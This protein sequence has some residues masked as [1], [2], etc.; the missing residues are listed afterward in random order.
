MPLPPTCT[1]YVRGLIFYPRFILS[2][3]MTIST[4]C[5]VDFV[6]R[7]SG[8]NLFIPQTQ[9]LSVNVAMVN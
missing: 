6:K 5:L 9:Y 3:N 8:Q 7:L 4:T 2:F 1:L